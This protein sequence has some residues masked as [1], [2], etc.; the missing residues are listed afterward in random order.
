MI[1]KRDLT[2]LCFAGLRPSIRDKLELYEF[3][4]VNQLLQMAISVES[5]LKESRETYKSNRHNV[6][7]V[8][9]HS[10]CS[11]DDNKK[12]YPAEIKWPT[13]NKMV[14]CPSLKLIHKNRGKR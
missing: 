10:D 12:I 4:N 3:V 13:E 6:H 7:V 9:D 2:D 1:S 11:N 14:T 5:C 8:D